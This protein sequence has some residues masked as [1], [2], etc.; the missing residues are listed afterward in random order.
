[1]AQKQDKNPKNSNKP[2]SQRAMVKL[3]VP[4]PAQLPLVA[5]RDGVIFPHTESVLV[6]GRSGSKQAILAA[7]E[8]NNLLVIAA[9]KDGRKKNISP[10]DIYP[11]ATLCQVERTLSHEG[12]LHVMVRGLRRVRVAEFVQQKPFFLVTAKEL[13]QELIE[14]DEFKALLNHLVTLFKKTIQA[15]KPVEFFNFIKLASGVKSPEIIDHIASTLELPTKEKQALL[16]ELNVNARLKM[17]IDYLSQEQRILNIEQSISQKTKQQLDERMR[18]SILRE[19]MSVIQKELGESEDED[20]KEL[21]KKLAKAGLPKKI[22]TKVK[23]EIKRLSQ[24]SAMHSEYAYIHTW[25]ETVLSLPWNKTSKEESS[26]TKA[27][28]VLDDQHY[29]LEKVKERVL[30]HLAV[31]QLKEKQASKKAKTDKKKD[32]SSSRAGRSSSENAKLSTILCF[33]G[34]PG[35]GKT[36]IG[37]SIAEALGRE[38]V[39]VSLGG[40]RDESEI[41]GHRR[42]YVGALPGRIIQGISQANTKNPVFVLDEI[43][44]LGADFRGDPS[45]A[46]LEAL[47]PEQN[48]EFSDHYLGV[49]FDLSEV[50]FITTANVLHTIPAALRDRLEIVEY[51]GYTFD[52]K[53]QI[54]K[55]Y[56]LP[57]VIGGS[58]LQTS[59]LNIND[60]A[61][62]EIITHY[63]R[64]A[65]VRQLKRELAK[66][67]RKTARII[68]EKKKKSLRVTKR[69]L[70]E[71]LGPPKYLDTIT[72]KT[73]MVGLVNGLAWTSTGGDILPI[74][75]SVVTGK[76]E[77]TLTGQLGKVMQESA[78]AALT[79]VK[80]HSQAL[81]V[82]AK[83]FEKKHVHIHVP[84]GAVPKD[85]PSAG[86]A[87][88][89]A[90]ASAFLNQPVRRDIAM[91]GEVTLRGRVLPIGGLKEKLIA[92]HRAG[93]KKVFIPHQNQKDLVEV[94]DNVRQD[95]QIVP[96][97]QAD[98][99]IKQSL[100]G[101]TK[102]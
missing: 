43:D 93:I 37:R 3:P 27:A 91:T 98:E 26:L 6:F 64:E 53:F 81:G 63:T 2:Q 29:G 21:Q 69:N 82:S 74:E 5:L 15:G 96:V 16:E 24:M 71:L 97:E 7:E 1:M 77:I 42:T 65:G 52:E 13:T 50:M 76:E 94:P 100:V 38:F 87:M 9:Q 67:A 25:L 75:V 57:Q 49:P 30:E 61:L 40:I 60:A 8:K 92:A 32:G 41:R 66:I 56:L 70:D 58:G 44:K 23:K 20:I 102:K 47:D 85:G 14:T 28:E 4:K 31:L 59:S 95:L 10:D 79:F 11:T 39:K 72:E 46:L 68:A 62:M 80:S 54:A 90:L 33:V 86:V 101:K 55:R 89:T 45:A 36:S 51:S 88:T 48:H 73:P 34:P 12:D 35:V 19:R 17:V 83:A 78:R 99:A 22:E 84:E 18:E